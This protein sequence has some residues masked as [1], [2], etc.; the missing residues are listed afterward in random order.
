M[1]RFVYAIVALTIAA[2]PALAQQNPVANTLRQQLESKSKNLIAAAEEMPAD[3]YSYRPTPAQITFGHL[4]E[5][6]AGSNNTLCGAISG[7]AA[8]KSEVKET[9]G[10]DKLVQALKDSFAF[11]STSLAKVDDSKLG[12]E[13]S[14][15]GRKASR[16]QAMFG[17]SNDWAD[18]YA[19]A[20][21]YLRLNGMLPPTAKGKK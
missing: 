11:C 21:M 5:H 6:I 13:L 1:K 20:A 4:M 16:A 19:G 9:E 18:H 8:P 2:L 12:D 14:I 10:K 7:E 3:K 15:F 17:L